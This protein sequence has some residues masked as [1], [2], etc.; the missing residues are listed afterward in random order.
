[1]HK[2][3]AWAPPLLARFVTGTLFFVSGW[4]KIHALEKF[5]TDFV[6]WGIPEPRLMAPFVAWSEFVFGALLIVGLL[7]R[8]ASLAMLINM[9]MA[10]FTVQI[11]AVHTVGNFLYLPEVSLLALLFW[12]MIE[13]AGIVSVDALL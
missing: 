7:S 13:G 8:L 3:L 1:M 4:D 10:L 11:K 9:G 6:R 5:V 2:L 12:L